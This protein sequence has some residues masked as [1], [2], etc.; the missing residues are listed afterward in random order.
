MGAK[1][2]PVDDAV[3]SPTGG[4]TGEQSSPLLPK[5]PFSRGALRGGLIPVATDHH[6]SGASEGDGFL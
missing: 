6:L 1:D 2:G 3:A 4:L 5:G